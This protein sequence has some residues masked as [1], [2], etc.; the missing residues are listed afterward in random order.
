ME[1]LGSRSGRSSWGMELRFSGSP[2]PDC[3]VCRQA[4]LSSLFFTPGS[5][6]WRTLLNLLGPQTPG[7]TSSSSKFPSKKKLGTKSLVL[8]QG[9][10]SRPQAGG[11]SSKSVS[12][13]ASYLEANLA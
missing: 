7:L 13:P 4:V 1:F 5:C 2:V 11:A 8:L 12:Y 6:F 9:S 10:F 3:I